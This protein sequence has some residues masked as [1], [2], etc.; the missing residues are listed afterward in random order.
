LHSRLQAFFGAP[1]SR[2]GNAAE[3]ARVVTGTRRRHKRG[4]D[5]S[6][7]PAAAAAALPDNA[8]PRQARLAAA[9]AKAAEA[10]GGRSKIRELPVPKS[11]NRCNNKKTATAA[12][13][14]AATSVRTS[15]HP[16]FLD[17]QARSSQA[18]SFCQNKI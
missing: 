16:N 17:P 10:P 7:N 4:S 2:K 6:S 9:A 11:D 14:A 15:T 3:A 8:V 5:N 18:R 1:A 13:A 12:A